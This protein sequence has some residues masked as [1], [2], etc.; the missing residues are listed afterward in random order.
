MLG[1]DRAACSPDGAVDQIRDVVV[2]LVVAGGGNIGH[3]MKIAVADMAIAQDDGVWP[4]LL[5]GGL[6]LV[7]EFDQSPGW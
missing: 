5:E 7:D 4:T 2:G 3:K 6:D 1:G